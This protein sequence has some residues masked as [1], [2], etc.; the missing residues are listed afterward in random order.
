MREEL[1]EHYRV[2][3]CPDPFPPPPPPPPPGPE[4]KQLP[5]S[6]MNCYKKLK[7]C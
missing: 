2:R 3:F 1:L 4:D 7:N 5:V 6:L